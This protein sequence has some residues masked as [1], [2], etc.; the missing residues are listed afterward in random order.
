MTRPVVAAIRDAAANRTWDPLDTFIR[1]QPAEWHVTPVQEPNEYANC[2]PLRGCAYELSS[3]CEQAAQNANPT[4]R[5]FLH[6]ARCNVVCQQPSVKDG[7]VSRGLVVGQWRE[8]PALS[9][10]LQ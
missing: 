1:D 8:P 10:G 5:P 9:R 2:L 6:H 4:E 3:R 7:E